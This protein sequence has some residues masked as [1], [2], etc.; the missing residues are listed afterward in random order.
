MYGDSLFLYEGI[1]MDFNTNFFYVLGLSY[2]GTNLWHDEVGKDVSKSHS[3][4]A[5]LWPFLSDDFI[6]RL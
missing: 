2:Y 6:F 5:M 4:R 3:V 1:V